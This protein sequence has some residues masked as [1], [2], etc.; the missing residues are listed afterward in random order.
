MS[1]GS[2]T[3]P[4]R[5]SRCRRP[6][7]HPPR[8]PRNLVVLPYHHH[9]PSTLPVSPSPSGPQL[10]ERFRSGGNSSILNGRPDLR[11]LEVHPVKRVLLVLRGSSLS[12]LCTFLT[13]YLLPSD[14]GLPIYTSDRTCLFNKCLE[15]GHYLYVKNV[16]FI[17]P[18]G[19]YVLY[20]RGSH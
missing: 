12:F 13:G 8:G 16:S 4:N 3:V 19:F 11:D 7:T 18:L 5:S 6:S 1:S 15:R 2:S 10:R 20:I 9:D 14:T 17:V